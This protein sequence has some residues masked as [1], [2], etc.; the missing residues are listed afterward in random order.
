M[1]VQVGKLKTADYS[2]RYSNDDGVVRRVVSLVVLIVKL[3]VVVVMVMIL[4]TVVMA[5]MV[6]MVMVMMRVT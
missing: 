6:I 1:V 5:A 3:R 4:M 2:G